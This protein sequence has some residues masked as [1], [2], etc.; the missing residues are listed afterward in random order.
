[1]PRCAKPWVRT[2]PIEVS[3][4]GNIFAYL[5]GIKSM[6]ELKLTLLVLAKARDDS[7]T[8]IGEQEMATLTGL[9]ATDLSKGI[10]EMLAR[11][12]VLRRRTKD[13][14]EYRVPLAGLGECFPAASLCSTPKINLAA[15]APYFART[16]FLDLLPE[17]VKMARELNYGQEEMIE[18]I[19]KVADKLKTD[20]PTRNRS[21]WFTTVYK[22]KLREARA[23]L[24]AF[25]TRNMGRRHG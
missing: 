11:G 15:L 4:V 19:C 13:G 2:W 16:G 22:E 8:K 14:C 17:A 6:P 18:A 10:K 9:T 25:R 1:L 24:L 21:G 7:W 5:L 3:A 20:P 23:D 12:F